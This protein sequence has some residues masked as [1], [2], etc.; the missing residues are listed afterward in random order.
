MPMAPRAL[1]GG[2]L[3]LLLLM[4]TFP[5]MSQENNL[6]APQTSL[7]LQYFSAISLTAA[8]RD[9]SFCPEDPTIPLYAKGYA[10]QNVFSEHATLIS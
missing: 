6:L 3:A 4:S 7:N 9:R 5:H 2:F 1:L 8:C 10:R